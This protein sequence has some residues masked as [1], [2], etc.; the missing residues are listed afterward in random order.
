MP[1][2]QGSL[3][4]QLVRLIA[5]A[6]LPFKVSSLLFSWSS[7]LCCDK[8]LTI[9]SLSSFVELQLLEHEHVKNNTRAKKAVTDR[10]QV[11]FQSGNSSHSPFLLSPC[12]QRHSLQRTCWIHGSKAS[13]CHRFKEGKQWNGS[14]S[15]SRHVIHKGKWNAEQH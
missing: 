14:V 4:H 5:S 6:N 12:V 15:K 3:D 11:V 13:Y 7:V 10:S 1:E 2:E 8:W 9:P